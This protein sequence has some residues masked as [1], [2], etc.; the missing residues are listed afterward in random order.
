MAVTYKYIYIRVHMYAGVYIVL[1]EHPSTDSLY[2]DVSSPL[3]QKTN[4]LLIL[5]KVFFLS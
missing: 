2:T 5:L 1:A 3:E 4:F